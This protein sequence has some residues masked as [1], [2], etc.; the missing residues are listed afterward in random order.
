MPQLSPISWTSV[1]SFFFMLIVNMSV[2]NWWSYFSYYC[3]NSIPM[4]NDIVR[5]RRLFFWGLGSVLLKY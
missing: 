1:F 4:N 3:V 5:R 2:I